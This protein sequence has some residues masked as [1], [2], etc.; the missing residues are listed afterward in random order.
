MGTGRRKFDP[1]PAVTSGVRWG[2]KGHRTMNTM[3]KRR[4]L[5]QYL[6][7]W[8]AQNNAPA[9]FIGELMDPKWIRNIKRDLSVLNERKNG[10]PF[11]YPDSMVIFC[12]MIKSFIKRYRDAQALAAG[13]LA[14]YGITCIS[15]SRLHERASWLASKQLRAA[16]VTD[17]RV[18]GSHVCD[19]PVSPGP[20]TV[21][22]DSTGMKLS[23]NGNWLRKKWNTDNTRGWVKLSLAVNTETDMV[24]AYSIADENRG[25]GPELLPLID[26]I[27]AAGHKVKKVLADGAYDDM[28]IWTG[29][30]RERRIEFVTNIRKDATGKFEGCFQRGLAVLKRKEIGEKEWKESVG[31]GERWKAE[32]TISD[33]KR[34]NGDE[35][36]ARKRDYMAYEI[37]WVVECHNLY[38]RGLLEL[39]DGE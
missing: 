32:C 21:A 5:K 4:E 24:M 6:R 1:A 3:T 2:G 36:T 33:F 29:M 28:D 18:M 15:Y 25:D 19:V 34:R 27:L 22:V 20:I 17:A 16:P 7:N 35:M 37:Y 26:D 39:R 23:K 11:V 31:Y 13:I 9:A 38:K 8:K 30:Y 12:I 10:R 14:I